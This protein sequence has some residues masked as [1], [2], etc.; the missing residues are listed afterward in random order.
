[1][2]KF[3][4]AG[5]WA[6]EGSGEVPDEKFNV[7]GGAIALGHPVGSTGARLVVTLM[8]EL[9]QEEGPLRPG[10]PVHRRRPGRRLCRDRKSVAEENGPWETIRGSLSRSRTRRP[11]WVSALR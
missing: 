11:M 2:K 5:A 10:H 1:M 8:H 9:G 7:N 6:I 4:H 3:H